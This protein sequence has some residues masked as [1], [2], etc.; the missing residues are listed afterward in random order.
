MHWKIFTDANTSEKAGKVLHKVIAR[1]ETNCSSEKVEPYHK[2][3]FVCSFSTSTET[4]SWSQSIF[5]ALSMA[6]KIGRGW[7]LTGDITEELDAWSN[8]SSVVG[9]QNIHLVVEQNA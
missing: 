5:Q 4:S 2:G 9:V 8:E 6:Q 7:V 1:L 3:G